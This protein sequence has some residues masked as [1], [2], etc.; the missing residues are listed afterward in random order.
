M[1]FC[2]LLPLCGDSYFRTYDL[3]SALSR[4]HLPFRI[5]NNQFAAISLLWFPSQNRTFS[6]P[7][8]YVPFYGFRP[9]TVR[10]PNQNRMF[11]GRKP[12]GFGSEN[13]KCSY[14]FAENPTFINT[15]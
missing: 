6:E 9:K 7:K 5:I 10:S 4:F 14:L 12:Y 1:R 13:V 11:L 3:L 8:P 15:N 2:V